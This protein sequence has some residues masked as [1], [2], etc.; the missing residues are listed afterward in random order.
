MKVFFNIIFAICVVAFLSTLGF[1]HTPEQGLVVAQA[2]IASSTPIVQ[3]ATVKPQTTASAETIISK[4]TLK[5]TSVTINSLEIPVVNTKTITSVPL[6]R[7]LATTTPIL[8][9]PQG[10]LTMQGVI[11]FTNTTRVENGNLSILTE[12]QALDR[13]AQIKLEDMVTKQYFEHVSPAGVG[14]PDLAKTV[15]Y[16]YV[17]VGENLALGDFSSDEDLVTAWMNSPGH[18]AN[19]LNTHFQE[20]GVAV[21]K[22]VYEGHNTWIAVQSF[23]MPLSSCPTLEIVIKTQIDSNNTQIANMKA[24]IDIQKTQLDT[25]SIGDQNYNTYVDQFNQLL[26]PY[27]SLVE[28]TRLLISKYNINVRAYNDCVNVA[29]TH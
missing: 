20:I 17:L 6:K 7:S 4:D 23:G 11:N 26:S 19:I 15:G 18:R 14:P 12:N 29:G 8:A 2:P 24:Q 10:I 21:G 3:E 28:S 25:I 5:K 16:A 9:N 22:G 13:D 27:D 1:R